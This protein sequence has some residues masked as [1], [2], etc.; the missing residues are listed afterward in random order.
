M[1]TAI[2]EKYSVKTKTIITAI[3]I[4][5]AVVLPQILHLAAGKALGEIWLPM[6][7]PVILA[8]FIAGPVV[9]AVAGDLSPVISFLISGMP[10]ALL[11]PFMAIELFSYGFFAGLLSKTKIPT[12]FQVLSVQVIG[13]LIRAAAILIAVFGFNYSLNPMMILTSIKTGICGIV[14]QLVLIPLAVYAVKRNEK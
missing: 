14:L 10:S 2:W 5:L 6:H 7:L 1:N 9:G 8:G 13:R 11:L 3:T 4:A 12:V